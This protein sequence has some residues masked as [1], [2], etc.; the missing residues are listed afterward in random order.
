MENYK[1]LKGPQVLTGVDI[2]LFTVTMANR[3]QSPQLTH[4]DPYYFR[5]SDAKNFDSEKERIWNFIKKELE[6]QYKARPRDDDIFRFH[7][8][9]RQNKT[10]VLSQIRKEFAVKHPLSLC[11]RKVVLLWMN[12]PQE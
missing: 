9:V 1:G 12:S 11:L 3:R 4:D 6:D 10:L 8:F 7:L 2:F 5:F